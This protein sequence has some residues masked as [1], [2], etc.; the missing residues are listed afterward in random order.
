MYDCME[1]EDGT[2]SHWTLDRIK[3]V[4]ASCSTPEEIEKRVHGRFVVVG[5]RKYGSFNIKKHVK[6]KHPVPRGW[7]IYVGADIGSGGKSGHPSALCYV[8]VKPDFTEGRVFLGWRGDKI[9]TTAGDVVKKNLEIKK[10]NKIVPTQ[11]FYDWSNKDFKNIAD[12]V[13]DPYSM[14]E[15][16]HD[17][18]EEV[19]NTLFKHDMLYIY[20]DPELVKLAGELATLKKDTEK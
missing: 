7:L 14:A 20:E 18:G 19:I 3:A 13:G 5:G 10:E 8:A 6:P 11:Q 2:L 15:K 17:I 12:S 1:Y 16:G 9:V 4:E